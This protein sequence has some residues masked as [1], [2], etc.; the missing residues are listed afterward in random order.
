MILSDRPEEMVASSCLV[1][2]E[3]AVEDQSTVL[4]GLSLPGVGHEGIHIE[5]VVTRAAPLS[6]ER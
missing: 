4:D 3:V 1:D 6:N 5:D 2:F